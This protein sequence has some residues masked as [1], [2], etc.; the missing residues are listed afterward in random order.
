L[1]LRYNNGNKPYN[2]TE[3]SL[4][5]T[6]ESVQL[7]ENILHKIWVGFKGVFTSL[8]KSYKH[9]LDDLEARVAQL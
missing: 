7:K 5:I 2:N 9:R 4:S 3:T 8:F 1:V 6:K